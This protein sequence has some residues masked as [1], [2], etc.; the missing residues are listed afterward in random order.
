MQGGTSWQ[1]HHREQQHWNTWNTGR[2]VDSIGSESVLLPSH[3]FADSQA[4]ARA[5]DAADGVIDGKS[6]GTEVAVRRSG[7][8][9]PPVLAASQAQARALDAAD[10]VID[11][12]AF[13]QQVGVRRAGPAGP[14]GPH[15]FA[16]S[17]AHARALDAAD[18][19]IDG[20]AFGQQVAVSRHGG[21]SQKILAHSQAEARALDAADGVLD[22]RAFGSQVGVAPRW[23]P[24][25]ST[26]YGSPPITQPQPH[27]GQ[28]AASDAV[29]LGPFVVG[30]PA[31]LTPTAWAVQ[32]PTATP[33]IP[34]VSPAPV[35]AAVVPPATYGVGPAI[36]PQPAWPQYHL[37]QLLVLPAS[38]AYPAGFFPGGTTIV[39]AP[40]S[41][42]PPVL[43]TTP[44]PY[45]FGL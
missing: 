40:I 28:V 19:V 15:V 10:G 13:G 31:A 25:A 22:G 42:P 6:F 8:V 4:G 2:G 39:G 20:R 9:A 29:H 43:A 11:G 24:T 14:Q 26:T 34:A 27:V 37:T 18:G 30:Q 21:A 36:L 23:F 16:D 44:F 35:V 7:P 32:F 45:T 41:I 33:V 17:Q 3:L 5:L 38:P 12:R 1:V